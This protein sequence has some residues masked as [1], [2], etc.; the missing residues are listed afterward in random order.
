MLHTGRFQCDVQQLLG[1]LLTSEVENE[2]VL[3]V[4]VF[5]G[6]I[7][8]KKYSCNKIEHWNQEYNQTRI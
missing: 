2:G 6:C 1:D 3:V 5:S 8:F 7:C 4:Y